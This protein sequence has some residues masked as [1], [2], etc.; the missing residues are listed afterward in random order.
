[1]K[2]LSE[3]AL[4]LL[5][6]LFVA[7][8]NSNSLESNAV[9]DSADTPAFP[10]QLCGLPGGVCDGCPIACNCSKESHCGCHDPNGAAT[11]RDACNCTPIVVGNPPDLVSLVDGNVKAAEPPPGL[12]VP[13]SHPQKPAT[14]KPAA[15]PLAQPLAAPVGHW[16]FRSY[17]RRGQFTERVWVWDRPPAAKPIAQATVRVA[18]PLYFYGGSSCSSGGCRSCR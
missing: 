9:A 6:A 2:I 8:A 14:V 17:G 4:L 11:P 7:S 18:K 5:A 10:S 1:M 15:K 16:E 12:L 13:V 3:L